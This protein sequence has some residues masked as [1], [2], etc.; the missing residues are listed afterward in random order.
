MEAVFVDD[1]VAYAEEL[2]DREWSTDHVQFIP[3]GSREIG[4]LSSREIAKRVAEEVGDDDAV[5]FINVNLKSEGK[6]RQDQAGVEVLKFLRLTERF[7]VRKN[8]AQD[9]HCV[10][11]SFQSL[12]QIL[13]D[14]PSSLI[15]CSDGVTF[16]RLPSDLPGLDLQELA[17]EKAPVDELDKFLRG[18][19][20]LPDERHSWAN[21]WAARQMIKLYRLEKASSVRHKEQESSDIPKPSKTKSV[22]NRGGDKLDITGIYEEVNKPEIR[23]VLYLFDKSKKIKNRF[24]RE[25]IGEINKQ[26]DIINGKNLRIGI[27][28]D[29]SRDISRGAELN[30][31]WKDVYSYVFHENQKSVVDLLD[32]DNLNVVL[33]PSNPESLNKL[34]ERI[35][36]GESGFNFDPFACLLLD[37]RLL[38]DS[39][40]P[41]AVAS[42]SGVKVLEKIRQVEPTLPVIVTTASNKFSSFLEINKTGADAYWV[43]QGIDER[44]RVEETISNYKRLLQIVSGAMG[45]KY[46]FFRKIG[47]EVKKL[48]Y[49]GNIWC[50][51]YRWDN[52][53]TTKGRKDKIVKYLKG[54]IVMM[55]KYLK[56][57]VIGKGYV[58]SQR[59]R[60][61]EKEVT[62]WSVIQHLGKIIEEVHRFDQLP[63]KE[64]KS[65]KIGD[66]KIVGDSLEGRRDWFGFKLYSI[67][68]KASHLDEARTKVEW[69]TLIEFF[70]YMICYLNFG[71]GEG[72]KKNKRSEIPSLRNMTRSDD[73]YRKKWNEIMMHEEDKIIFR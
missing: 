40:K 39:T 36:S 31:G 51:G 17:T 58:V 11:Y 3:A 25:D 70:T 73:Q 45:S 61:A 6:S 42:A 50:E 46:Q 15:I 49:S 69:D 5:V 41:G 24:E 38:K 53:E 33:D 10:M 27:I 23:N 8:R 22:Y 68:N 13:R 72:A 19:F 60:E 65:K 44:R 62:T 1:N 59:E 2:T 14:E 9:V 71:P 47:I 26:R 56:K 16:K 67:R 57:E 21:W 37:L 66:G 18:E 63:Y 54:S 4:D 32:E 30:Y 43:K 64:R 20:R 29:E 34:L 7:G 55:R 35:G 12:E 52:G 28:D 48:K